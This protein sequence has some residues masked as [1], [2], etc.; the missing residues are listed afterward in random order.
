MNIPTFLRALPAVLT[1]AI[2]APVLSAKETEKPKTEKQA[3]K[4]YPLDVCI[5]SGD[6]L[7]EMGKPFVFVHEGREIK[8]CCKSCKEDFESEPAKYLKQLEGK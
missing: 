1:L 8:L 7:G 6:K 2:S 4:P 3:A 5:V